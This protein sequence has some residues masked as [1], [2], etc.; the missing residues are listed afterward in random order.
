MVVSQSHEVFGAG[1][2]VEADQV[3][4]I[5]GIGVPCVDDILEAG[6]RRMTVVVALVFVV[7]VAFLVHL[8]RVPVAFFRNALRSPVCPHAELGIA[9][10]LG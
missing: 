3:L 10:P 9:E 5:P 1:G 6:L 4:G 8:A 7:A 2:F